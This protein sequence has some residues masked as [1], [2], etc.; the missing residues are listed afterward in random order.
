MNSEKPSDFLADTI[1]A[2]A[3]DVANAP[4]PTLARYLEL[5]EQLAHHNRRYYE[6]DD[7]TITDDAYDAL[8]REARTLAQAHPDYIQE[9]EKQV[10]RSPLAD[11]GPAQVSDPT[12]TVGGMPS[13]AF[14]NVT[15]PTAMTSL[16]NVFDDAELLGFQDKLAR[17]LN[18]PPESL[19]ERPM[20]YTCELKIDGLSINL[21]YQH[22]EL[23]WA[24]TRGN[25]TVGE[26]VTAQLLTIEGIPQRLPGLTGELEVRGEVYLSRQDFASYN[27]RAEELGLALLKNPRNGA[28][29]ALRQKDP[30][31]TRSRGLKAIFYS[32]GKHDSVAVS[33]QWEALEWLGAHGFAVSPYSRRV[34]DLAGALAYHADLLAQRPTLPFDVDGT[35]IKLDSLYLQQEAGFTS[36]APK[37]A[38]AYKFPVEEVETVLEDISVSVGRTGKL[39]PLAHL[40]PRLI[41]GSTV[42]KATLHNEDYI[43]DMDL[44]IGDTVLVRKSGGVIPQIMGVVLDKRPADAAPYQFPAHCPACGEPVVRREEDANTFCVNPLCPAQD[45]RAIEYFVSRGA[46]D[47]QGMGEKLIMQLLDAGLVQGPADLYTLSAEQLSGLERGGEKKA[48]N[49][50]RELEESKTKPL[51][52]FINALGIPGVGQR[53][54]QA[55]AATF[56]TLDAF[57]AA[58]PEAIEAVPGLG[59]V[60]AGKVVDALALPKTQAT[61]QKLR[62]AGLNPQQAPQTRTQELAGLNFVLTGSLSRPRETL[63][64]LL[65]QHGARVTGSVTGKTNY[66]VAGEAAGSKLDKANELG[67]KLLDEA[68]LAELLAEKGVEI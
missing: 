5:M 1:T 8:V 25:G 58:T 50:L 18:L 53:N 4:L 22:G 62:A 45:F 46:L 43:K 47:I 2:P 42:S 7:P 27:T 65:E 38:I 63:K 40:S 34:P 26:V 51:W 59:K 57:T 32:L 21:Y 6:Q 55:L 54:A 39:A 60:L 31:V 52:R 30:E 49:L 23:Q 17:A 35:V 64:A 24:A 12:A 16:D 48:Q 20:S 15:H 66:L 10:S 44:R 37:W 67:I 13:S 14:A 41:E 61:L 3:N 33:S 56:G 68:G 11:T 19:A 36:R 29:G 28:A 9:W